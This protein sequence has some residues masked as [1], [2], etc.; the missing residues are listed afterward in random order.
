MK[1]SADTC[2]FEWS[3]EHTYK[4]LLVFVMHE[5]TQVWVPHVYPIDHPCAAGAEFIRKKILRTIVRTMAHTPAQGSMHIRI[6]PTNFPATNEIL[7]RIWGEAYTHHFGNTL[8]IGSIRYADMLDTTDALASAVSL[9]NTGIHVGSLNNKNGRAHASVIQ[10]QETSTHRQTDNEH[11]GSIMNEHTQPIPVQPPQNEEQPRVVPTVTSAAPTLPE[12]VPATAASTDT[13]QGPSTT[14]VSQEPENIQEEPVAPTVATPIPLPAPEMTPPQKEVLPRHERENKKK[15]LYMIQGNIDDSGRPNTQVTQKDMDM[16]TV[17]VNN[18]EREVN[19]LKS[20]Y[21]DDADGTLGI[22]TQAITVL[23]STL[24]KAQETFMHKA[25]KTQQ[26]SNAS[27]PVGTTESGQSMDSTSAPTPAPVPVPAPVIASVP[28]A[29]PMVTPVSSTS[30]LL[31]E[32]LKKETEELNQRLARMQTEH[33]QAIAD[34]RAAHQTTPNAAPPAA[35][36]T[37]PTTPPPTT[38]ATPQPG[39]AWW[40]NHIGII[41][42]GITAVGIVALIIY[43]FGGYDMGHPSSIS[44]E[45]LKMLKNKE[46]T[47]RHLPKINKGLGVTPPALEVQVHTQENGII[48]AA[49]SQDIKLYREQTKQVLDSLST[50]SSLK[51]TNQPVPT[52]LPGTTITESGKHNRVSGNG[53]VYNSGIQMNT[54]YAPQYHIHLAPT[55]STPHTPQPSCTPTHSTQEGVHKKITLNRGDTARY[56]LK[57]RETLRYSTAASTADID[58]QARGLD[59]VW[60]NYYELRDTNPVEST[61]VTAFRFTLKPDSELEQTDLLLTVTQG[62]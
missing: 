22:F 62:T 9:I 15:W 61:Y 18:A 4:S 1:I 27:P 60:R 8:E 24:S 13:S 2:L 40:S 33:A 14:H 51:S 34:I 30:D 43:M 16:L 50:L 41:L 58:I 20:T 28:V 44:S 7:V 55:N 32:Q 11:T 29:T 56:D 49:T 5:G 25:A 26:S 21:A 23:R 39:D 47:G 42:L 37:P 48:S 19:S 45:Q 31:L 36:A 38:P 10:Q 46:E 12:S 6:G 3:G 35:Q 54:T 52:T 53:N 17:M 57:L 59:G